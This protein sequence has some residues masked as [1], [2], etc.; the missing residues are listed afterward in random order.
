MTH[1]KYIVSVDLGGTKILSVL[2]DKKGNKLEKDKCPTD[3]SKGAKKIVSDISTSVKDLIKKANIKEKEVKCIA[4]GVPGTVNPKNGLIFSAPNLGITNFNI[5]DELKKYFDIPAA[6]ENDANLGMLGIKHYGVAKKANNV[7]GVFVGTGIG[8]ALIFDGKLYRGSDFSAG[9]IGHILV[10]KNGPQCGCGRFGCFEAVAS[11]TSLVRDI[12]VDIKNGSRSILKEYVMN[13]QKIKSKALADA[14]KNQDDLTIKHL[15]E[16][17]EVIGEVLASLDNLLDLD[18]IVLAGGLIEATGKF[19]LPLIKK[20][21]SVVSLKSLKN[22]KKIIV[23][24]LGDYAAVYG[25]IVLAN[26]I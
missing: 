8:G 2:L 19:M 1:K 15:T 24:K 25:G 26:D 5:K 4:L 3:T 9:E 20:S 17:S 13:N 14:I 16:K 22:S 6:V 21:F 11:R 10:R 23:S 12:T 7:L 18:A